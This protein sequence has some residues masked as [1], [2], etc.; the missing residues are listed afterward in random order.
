MAKLLLAKEVIEDKIPI[1]KNKC[2][3]LSKQ[4]L[5]P[6][7]RVILVGDNTASQIYVRN[8][9]KLC[10]RVGAEFE[11]IK[12]DKEISRQ[13][14]LAEIDQMNNDPSITG[15]FVQLPVPK[16]LQDIDVT[17]LINPHKDVDGFHSESIVNIYKNGHEGFIPCTPKGI[18][19]LL[20]HYNIPIAG[21][22]C[23]IIGRSLIVGKP[24]SMLL[25]NENA[26]VTLCHSKTKDIAYFTKQ[27]DI[28]ISAVGKAKFINSNYVNSD[29]DQTLIDVGMNKDDQGKLCGD[30][31][32]ADVE[33]HVKSITPVPGGVGPLT[34]FSLIEN[35]IQSTEDILKS[36]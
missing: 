35:L 32:L 21:K 36:R 23:V 12:L 15:C 13:E 10:Q 7:M 2:L 25:T 3:E 9:E 27:A 5:T 17:G 34:V 28:I 1:L 11:L 6:K 30:I 26:T 16:H 4:G 18:I 20:K 22:H 29:K 24:M 19:T 14:F 33:N 31:D 8:K